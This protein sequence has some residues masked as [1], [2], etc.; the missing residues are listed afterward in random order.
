MA[1]QGADRSNT[2]SN[3]HNSAEDH[4]KRVK[5]EIKKSRMADETHRAAAL[6]SLIRRQKYDRSVKKELM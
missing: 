6:S 5:A 2:R 3:S 4:L 1:V